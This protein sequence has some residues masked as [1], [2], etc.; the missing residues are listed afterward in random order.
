MWQT[1]SPRL[2][3]HR[4]LP[5]RLTQANRVTTA[6]VLGLALVATMRIRAQ[7]CQETAQSQIQDALDRTTNRILLREVVDDYG[8]E[9]KRILVQ[10]A[11]DENQTPQRRGQAIRLL[12][13]H[14]SEAGE[15]LL[16]AMLDDPRTVCS[17]VTPLQDYRDPQLIPK[18]I[19]MLDDHRSC[20]EVV[21]FSIGGHD[22]EQKTGVYLSDEI[23]GAL[24]RLTGKRFEEERDLFVIGHRATQPWKDWWSENRDAFQAAPSSFMVPER[25]DRNDDYPCS[26]QKI[27][28]SP[29]G[30]KAFSAGKNYDPWVR[31]WDIETQRQIWTV[32]T[33]KDEDAESAVVSPD[34]RMIA[35]GTSNG[36]LKV[37]D[38]ATGSRLHFLVIGRAVDAVAFSPDGTIL[39]SASDDGSIRLFDTKTWCETKHLDNS[40]MTES[41]AFSPDG[42]LLAAATFEKA[43]LW[44]LASGKELRSFQVRPGKTP[45]V[46]AD[47]GEHDAQLWR[48]AW[49]VAFSMDGKFLGT[50]SSAAVQ[51]WNPSTGQEVFSTSS[52]G[53]VGSLHFSPDGQWVIWGND[54]D[55]IVRWNPATRKRSRIKNEFS[56][57]DTAMTPD[58]KL[59]LS[60]G[61]GTEIAVFDLGTQRKV[62]VLGCSKPK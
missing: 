14:R 23:V 53:Q 7:Q 32:P 51:I 35:L 46:F 42:S 19:A 49:Q 5:R 34:S 41:I 59:I 61:A 38:A 28:V 62:G 4:L 18:L 56:L 54:H 60:P 12:G 20:G 55:Q 36:A 52:N 21:R 26:V 44:D 22:K 37:F 40:D 48:M 3:R 45:R 17:A 9:A 43:R 33:V 11:G 16:L 29:D 47:V 15:K 57:G 30:K 2:P 39:A 50:G 58:G 27:A 6:L 31:A 13:E 1:D 24:E 25:T 10:I 8:E